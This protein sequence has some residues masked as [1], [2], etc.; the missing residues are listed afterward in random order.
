MFIWLGFKLICPDEKCLCVMTWV[1]LNVS[2]RIQYC[3]QEIVIMRE[4]M[5]NKMC[6]NCVRLPNN[7]LDI[8]NHVSLERRD[9]YFTL[10]TYINTAQR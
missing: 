2:I 7:S 6:R 10:S 5:V 8:P 1:L 9:S 4:D 3:S